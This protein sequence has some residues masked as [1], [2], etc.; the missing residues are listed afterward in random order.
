[1]E[2]QIFDSRQA[3]GQAAANDLTNILTATLVERGQA[4]IILATGNSQ[5]EFLRALA[6]KPEIAW[7]KITVFQMDEY[8]GI[9]PFHS[10]SFRRFHRE[11]LVNLVH[12]KMF[13][14]IEGDAPDIDVELAR[15]TALLQEHEPVACVMGIGE[16]GHLAF[17]DPPA[18]FHTTKT[19]HVV[20]LDEACRRQ[21]VGEG[22]FP[23]LQ[24]VP[25]QALSLTVLALLKPPHVLVITPET[26]KAH[27]V[28]AALE[29]PVTPDCPASILQTRPHVHL[30]LDHDSASLLIH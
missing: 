26:R 17:N 4:A 5:I 3:L 23:T 10:A 29:G 22:H 24:D 11:H 27:A 8:L 21:Q 30:Y 12:P 28:Q 7:D 14:G 16:N 15:Y 2:I 13:Y 18:D 1:M 9:S 6:A 25:T 19:I 20:T